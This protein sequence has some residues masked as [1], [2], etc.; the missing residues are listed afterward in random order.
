[1]LS[2]VEESA[3]SYTKVYQPDIYCPSCFFR[4]GPISGKKKVLLQITEKCNLH[5]KHCFVSATGKGN[6]ID[7]SMF[8]S[9]I[10][11]H[12][13][14]GSI[15]KVT[16]TGGEPLVYSKVANVVEMLTKNGISVGICSNATLVN[17]DLCEAL[18][19]LGNVHFNVSLD[20]FSELSHGH[21][22]GSAYSGIFDRT[23]SGIK[24][25]SDYKLLQG[26]LV[27][28]NKY[29]SLDEYVEICRFAK[30]LR[31]KYV[32]FNPLSE[33]GRG[34]DSVG[35]AYTSEL[36]CELKDRTAVFADASFEVVYI[37]FPN[38]EQL[39]LSGCV[40]GDIT[41]IFSNGDVAICP[42]M[43][44]SSKDRVSKYHYEN[45][46]IGNIFDTSFNYNDAIDHYSLPINSGYICAACKNSKCLKGCYAAKISKGLSLADADKELCPLA[47]K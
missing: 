5:C 42:Y 14:E 11:P 22:R 35:L 3:M 36:M 2:I 15:N 21:F 47:N 30:S 4:S 1:M 6:D 46:I 25:L 28:P 13:I 7:Y 33:F 43:A 45:F 26:V 12:L 31:A 10:L 17:V 9:T 24:L 44:F 41:Y 18:S 27:T 34:E 37:R 40:A 29:A 38:T 19:S 16:I 39:P 8:V 32:L 23:I 20:G